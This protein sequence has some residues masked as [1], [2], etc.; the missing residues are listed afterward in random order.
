M[1]SS[2]SSHRFSHREARKLFK[3]LFAASLFAPPGFGV[4]PIPLPVPVPFAVE[5][6]KPPIIHPFPVHHGH[7]GHHSHHF[8]GIHG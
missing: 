3:L 6:V 7:H 5:S 1:I 4:L 8:G 2:T